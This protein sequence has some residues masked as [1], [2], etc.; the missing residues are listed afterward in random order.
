MSQVAG[1]YGLRPVN[2]IGA[3]VWPGPGI[4]TFPLTA[5]QATGFFYGDPVGLV[6]GVPTPLAATPLAIASPAGAP[7]ASNPIGVFVGCSYQDPIR[8]FVNAQF[9]PAN[10]ISS[11]ATKVQVK[12]ADYPGL[13]MQVQATGSVPL[14]QIGMNAALS[15]F[16]AGSTLTGNSAVALLQSSIAVTGTLAVK[17]YDFVYNAS[18]SPGASSIPGDPYTDVLVIW[19]F[20]VHRYQ[21]STGL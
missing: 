1:P 9:L 2:H 6:A 7:A 12:I 3:L 13:V 19:N 5:N 18:P 17:I 20:G 15:N 4:H 11:G 21:I 14:S 16:G 8:G 10:A